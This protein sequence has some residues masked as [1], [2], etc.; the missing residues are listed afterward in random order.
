MAN[1]VVL[2]SDSC[3]NKKCLKTLIKHNCWS[4]ILLGAIMLGLG[5]VLRSAV[6]DT[7]SSSTVTSSGK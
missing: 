7:S 5:I 2:R 3:Y 1:D 6:F 4:A